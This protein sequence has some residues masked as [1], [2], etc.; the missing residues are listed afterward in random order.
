MEVFVT[1]VVLMVLVLLLKNN[2]P[3][4]PWKEKLKPSKGVMVVVAVPIL[5]VLSLGI[6]GSMFPKCGT[7]ACLLENVF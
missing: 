2:Q 7:V 6:V 3:A 4:V 5:I 1:I